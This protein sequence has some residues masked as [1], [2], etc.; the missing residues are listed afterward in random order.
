LNAV[1]VRYTSFNY[2][3]SEALNEIGAKQIYDE[4]FRARTRR[5][6]EAAVYVIVIEAIPNNHQLRFRRRYRS[7]KLLKIEL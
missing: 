7:L 2:P 1:D 6:D 4:H 3:L 5:I